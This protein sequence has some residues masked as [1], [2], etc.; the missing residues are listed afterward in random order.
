MKG[1]PAESVTPPLVSS[2]K[3]WS[4]SHID[5]MEATECRFPIAV[6]APAGQ[7]LK[8]PVSP[9]HLSGFVRMIPPVHEIAPALQRE[10]HRLQNMHLVSSHRICIFP[11]W[12]AGF[13]HQPH[14]MGQPFK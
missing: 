8:Q 9:S 6:R 4:C 1:S 3:L 10:T 12:N 14:R 7:A 11:D 5:T 2:K 13:A